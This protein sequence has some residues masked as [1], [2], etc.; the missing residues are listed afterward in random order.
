MDLTDI[1]DPIPQEEYARRVEERWKQEKERLQEDIAQN[2][3][4]FS[5]YLHAVTE[6]DAQLAR[7]ELKL[8]EVLDL[9]RRKG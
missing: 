3:K 2:A 8:D 6:K 9:L 1:K 4:L 5:K 7:I